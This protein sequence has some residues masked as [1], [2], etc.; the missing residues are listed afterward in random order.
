MD[1]VP[2]NQ[3]DVFSWNGTSDQQGAEEILKRMWIMPNRCAGRFSLVSLGAEAQSC[4]TN[5]PRQNDWG[6][7]G[8]D[9]PDARNYWGSLIYGS[10]NFVVRSFR[11]VSLRDG[12]DTNDRPQQK[13]NEYPDASPQ[14]GTS[15]VVNNNW[16]TNGLSK[17]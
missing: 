11:Q 4:L 1:E 14:P 3:G 2:L 6:D 5:L 10:V 7:S 17:H 16:L 12:G 9:E 15:A 13:N 8:A